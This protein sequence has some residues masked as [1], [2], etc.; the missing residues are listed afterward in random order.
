MGRV[1]DVSGRPSHCSRSAVFH[2]VGIYDRVEHFARCLVLNM[3]GDLRLV[4]SRSAVHLIKHGR[5]SDAKSGECVEAPFVGGLV[6]DERVLREGIVMLDILDRGE[7]LAALQLLDALQQV[8]LHAADHLAVNILGHFV[9]HG[10]VFVLCRFLDAVFLR[11][12]D[13]GVQ[14][15]PL[16]HGG[17]NRDFIM[18]KSL[19]DLD[20]ACVLPGIAVRSRCHRSRRRGCLRPS[21]RGRII[22]AAA[23]GERQAKRNH[24]ADEELFV[25]A[26]FLP[27]EFELL[28]E[29][30]EIPSSFHLSAGREQKN[31]DR[32]EK[33]GLCCRYSNRYVQ[34]LSVPKRSRTSRDGFL[35]S[36]PGTWNWER[37]A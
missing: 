11:L 20:L 18:E 1:F 15:L 13:D 16:Q 35:S 7:V 28:L 14:I 23:G 2:R 24:G 3:D 29:R 27:P 8:V 33:D 31:R 36:S 21:G 10:A 30:I 5:Q 34:N 9:G 26:F 4:R 19:V 12:R 32:P 22:F 25:H 6:H 17:R 37:C